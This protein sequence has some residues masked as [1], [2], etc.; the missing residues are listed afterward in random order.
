[1]QITAAALPRSCEF[2]DN[3]ASTATAIWLRTGAEF[4][5]AVFSDNRGGRNAGQSV[6]GWDGRGANPN[7][8]NVVADGQLTAAEARTGISDRWLYRLR[9]L[10]CLFVCVFVCVFVF[11][12]WNPRIA[13]DNLSVFLRCHE[14]TGICPLICPHV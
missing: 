4:V 1:M 8:T 12:F 10:A 2:Y 13:R 9:L 5:R 14:L 11:V 6:I 3:T 7:H